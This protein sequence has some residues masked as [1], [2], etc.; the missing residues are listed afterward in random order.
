[1]CRKLIFLILWMC[2]SLEL[3]SAGEIHVAGARAAGMGYCSASLT[4]EWS[5]FNNQAGLGW[6]KNF[7]I[8]IWY[9]NRFLLKE[10]GI[11]SAGAVLPFRGGT[12]A[13]TF[14]HFGFSLYSEM[15]T[16]IAFGRSF[17]KHFGVGVR[18]YYLRIHIAGDYGTRHMASF[19]IGFQYR[20]D[21]KWTI[22]VHFSNPVPVRVH[23]YQD[24]HLPVVIRLGIAYQPSRKFLATVEAEKDLSMK[25]NIRAGIEYHFAKPAYLRIGIMTNPVEFTFGFG[26]EPG[27]FRF[28]ISSSY[29]LYLGYSLQTSLVYVFR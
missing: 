27:K 15:K 11:K 23:R 19:E 1:M 22:G 4:D 12:F 5:G 7:T 20:A 3:F 14:E 21:E 6:Q 26:L 2:S 17:G 16:G 29:H 28:G 24:E 25:P 10:L 8:G 9:E 18:L 13:L